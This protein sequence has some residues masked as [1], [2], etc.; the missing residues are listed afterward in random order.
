[1]LVRPS[2]GS[3]LH[4]PCP[5]RNGKSLDLYDDVRICCET[6]IKLRTGEIAVAPVGALATLLFCLKDDEGKICGDFEVY[7]G[8]GQF[9]FALIE[10][11]KVLFQ[12][13]AVS[14]TP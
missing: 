8:S 9:G 6:E 12:S 2:V 1:M 11:S 5:D 14:D 4:R 13:S 3:E 10:L 7:L